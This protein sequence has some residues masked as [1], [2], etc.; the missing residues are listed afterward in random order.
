VLRYRHVLIAFDGSPEAELALEHAVALAH[1]SRARLAI[2]GFVPR[3]SWSVRDGLEER[4]RAAADG[5]PDDLEVTTRL[6]E[7][8]PARALL[9]AVREGEHDALVLGGAGISDHVLDDADVPVIV[10]HR[11]DDGPDLA[12]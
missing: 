6:L 9:R 12:A 10:I 2:V 4:L 8:D 5:V 11:P 1:V 7:G 3:P